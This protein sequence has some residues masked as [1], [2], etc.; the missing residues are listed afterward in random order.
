MNENPDE[1]LTFYSEVPIGAFFNLMETNKEILEEKFHETLIK[2]INDAGNPKEIGAVIIFN[3][4]YK[5]LANQR[6]SCNDFDIIWKQL[7]KNVPVIGF[8]TYGEQGST[9]GGIYWTS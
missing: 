3:C 1:S 6:C 5:H 7:G 2:A 9:S 4:I 8:N